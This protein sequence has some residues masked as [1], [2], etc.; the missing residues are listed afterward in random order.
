VNFG[1]PGPTALAIDAAISGTREQRSKAKN[2]YYHAAG[3]TVANCGRLPDAPDH[4]RLLTKMHRIQP[5]RARPLDAACENGR[6]LERSGF[7]KKI[8]HEKLRTAK[9]KDKNN[10]R[11]AHRKQIRN[12]HSPAPFFPKGPKPGLFGTWKSRL[13]KQSWASPPSAGKPF[14]TCAWD[15]RKL[16]HAGSF[17]VHLDL[18]IIIPS[19]QLWFSLSALGTSERGS[20]RFFFFTPPL[21]GVL[22]CDATS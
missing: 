6:D 4:T 17:I 7:V 9:K 22:Q 3:Q 20:D 5:Q 14:I 8:W 18:D 2:S 1:T 15:R 10:H 13:S 16:V 11:H 19:V 12:I 21:S